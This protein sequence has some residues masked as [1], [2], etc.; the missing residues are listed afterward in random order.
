MRIVKEAQPDPVVIVQGKVFNKATNQPIG[1]TIVYHDLS[2]GKDMGR[3]Q[4]N[5]QDGSYK[6]VLPYSKAYG[7]L[8][9]KEQ[10]LSESNN[11]DLSEVKV[12]QEVQ[13]DLYLTPLEIGKTITLNNVFFV[14]SKPDLLPESY[15]EIERLIKVLNDNPAIRIELSG[16]TD[17]VGSAALNKELSEKR[18]ASIKNYLVH[19]GIAESRISGKGYGGSKPIASNNTEETKKLNRRVEFTIVK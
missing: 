9:E 14:R 19:N 3:A 2:N 12:Y 8:A 6:I 1:A 15:P 11:L 13:Q 4:S 17:N 10:F 18:V 5:P 7:F 16:H